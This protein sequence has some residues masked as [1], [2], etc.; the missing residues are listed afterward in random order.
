MSTNLTPP[1]PWA[2]VNISGLAENRNFIFPKARKKT[3]YYSPFNF[4][5]IIISAL[6]IVLKG[7]SHQPGCWS[8]RI[9]VSSFCQRVG[10]CRARLASCDDFLGRV[11]AQRARQRQGTL[12]TKRPA[13]PLP[14][15]LA[16]FW[17][18]TW[19]NSASPLPSSNRQPLLPPSPHSHSPPPPLCAGNRNPKVCLCLIQEGQHCKRVGSRGSP[20]QEPFVPNCP[21]APILQGA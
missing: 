4:I 15:D 17:A 16:R 14:L 18:E 13:G 9:Q 19:F 6:K 8:A 11:C 10:G 7:K 12:T 5:I 20:L 1:L 3:K 2:T 21:D